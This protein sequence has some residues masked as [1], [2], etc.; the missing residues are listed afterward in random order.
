[1]EQRTI[2]KMFSRLEKNA[3]K[4]RSIVLEKII[5]YCVRN[6]VLIDEVIASYQEKQQSLFM[7]KDV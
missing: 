1:M 4:G 5:V 3:S 7:M 6:G 2:Q